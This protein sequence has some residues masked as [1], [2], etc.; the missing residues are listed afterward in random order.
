V[1]R[2]DFP[3][4]SKYLRACIAGVPFADLTKSARQKKSTVVFVQRPLYTI[5]TKGGA[6]KNSESSWL[7]ETRSCRHCK[8]APKCHRKS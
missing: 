5:R 3:R 8:I 1:R 7:S 4:Q 6:Q 2:G